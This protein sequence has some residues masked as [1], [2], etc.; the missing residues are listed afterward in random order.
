MDV[1]LLANYQAGN[2]D[3]IPAQY[4]SVAAVDRIV[5]VLRRVPAGTLT[6]G[7]PAGD[8]CWETPETPSSQTLTRNIAVWGHTLSPS[9]L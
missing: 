1:V 9:E 4:G 3:S 2:L 5:G 6:Q 8:P 7:S